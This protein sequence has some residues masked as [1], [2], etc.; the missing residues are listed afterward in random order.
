MKKDNQRLV[1]E[2]G[3]ACEMRVD[4]HVFDFNDD[5]IEDYLLCIDGSLYSGTAGHSVEIYIT[6]EDGSVECVRGIYLRFHNENRPSGHERFTVLN[7]KTD[8]YY[9]IVLPGSN[10]ILRYDKEEGGYVFQET[11]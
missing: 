11:E 10:R 3:S 6:K 1:D 9:A 7:E 2:N 4:Y 8:G 5:G